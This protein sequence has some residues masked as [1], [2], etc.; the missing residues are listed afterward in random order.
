VA[1]HPRSPVGAGGKRGIPCPREYRHRSGRARL[2]DL[3]TQ[4]VADGDARAE[5]LKLA[6]RKIVEEALEAEVAEALGRDYYEFYSCLPLGLGQTQQASAGVG[7]SGIWLD[8]TFMSRIQVGLERRG[9][10]DAG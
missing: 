1:S 4:G 9:Q 10:P 7:P 3:L 2:D 8:P 5:L 6:V